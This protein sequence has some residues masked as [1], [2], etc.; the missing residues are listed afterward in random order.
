[1]DSARD[2]IPTAAVSYTHLDVY[3]RQE[4]AYQLNQEKNNAVVGGMLWLRMGTRRI[5]TV[6]DLSH[7]DLDKIEEDEK[8]FRIGCMCTL[9]DLETHERLGQYFDGVFKNAVEHIVGVQ[10]RNMA[11]VGG[12]VFSKFGFSDLSTVLMAF[13]CQVE[14]YKG[15][16]VSIA[17]FM[18]M[19]R[20]RDILIRIHI[21]KDDRKV[22]YFTHRLSAT[23][24]P[25]LTCAEMC[26]RDSANIADGLYAVKKL[27]FD[28][29]KL[30]LAE[31]K[32]ALEDNYGKGIGKE[33][34]DAIYAQ[35][36]QQLKSNGMNLSQEEEKKIYSL[37][38]DGGVTAE[39]KAKYD[40]LL[41]WI[42]ELPK[43]GNDIREIDDFAREA[44]YTYTKPLE[45]YKNPRGGQYQA[46]L[47]VYKRQ[48]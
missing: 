16:V 33:K 7:L 29:K 45:K 44:A 26:I 12:S 6:I 8:E 40:E 32:K 9:H 25:V 42:S 22:A 5:K 13:D 24:F 20:D 39:E 21:K 41:K 2:L 17:D 35:I 28:E 18:E 1:M 27:V 34:A 38:S 3:K 10:F 11:T 36:V 47:D 31:Y 15:G 19:P 48:I 46:G 23:D 4:Q 37:V 14:L 30:T 43:F